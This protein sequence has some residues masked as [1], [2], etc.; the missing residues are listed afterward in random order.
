[1]VLVGATIHFPEQAR[2]IMPETSPDKLTAETME[3]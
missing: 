3:R 1:M 2:D